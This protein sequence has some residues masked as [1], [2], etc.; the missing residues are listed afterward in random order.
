MLTRISHT[1][2]TP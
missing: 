1:V 2:R